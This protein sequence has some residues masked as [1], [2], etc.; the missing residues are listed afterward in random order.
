MQR[1]FVTRELVK[2]WIITDLLDYNPK[3]N[4]IDTDDLKEDVFVVR[5]NQHTN[6]QINGIKW[7]MTSYLFWYKDIEY[8]L[9]SEKRHVLR[10]LRM[11]LPRPIPAPIIHTAYISTKF[12]ADPD[13]KLFV[14]TLLEY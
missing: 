8:E 7:S 6:N 4:I 10:D 2:T 13:T 12:K 11:H 9:G 3:I 5:K 14:D 1:G